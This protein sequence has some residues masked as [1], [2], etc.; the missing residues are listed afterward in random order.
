MALIGPDGAINELPPSMRRIAYGALVAAGLTAGY[1]TVIQAP[2]ADAKDKTQ[3]NSVR[4][5]KVEAN[6]TTIK[7]DVSDIKTTSAARDQK[8]DDMKETMATINAKLD[9]LLTQ[10]KKSSPYP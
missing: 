2:L 4:I 9:R 10:G 8:I 3:A 7:N 1:F 6:I 5:D